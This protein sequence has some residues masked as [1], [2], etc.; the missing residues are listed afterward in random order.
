M[1]SIN[2]KSFSPTG[3][4]LPFGDFFLSNKFVLSLVPILDLLKN[5]KLTVEK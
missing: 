2:D 1:G 3:T 5:I 4:L